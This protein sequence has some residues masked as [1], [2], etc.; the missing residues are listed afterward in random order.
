[1]SGMASLF[2][3]SGLFN[4]YALGNLDENKIHQV[5]VLSGAFLFST[6]KILQQLNG[7]DEG[8]FMYGEDIDLSYRIQQSGY[9]NFYL[10]NNPIVHFKGES[11]KK[12]KQYVK[13]FYNAMDVFL[14]KHY[15]G[16]SGK[17]LKVSVHIA[18]FLSQIKHQKKMNAVPETGSGHEH[19]I[20]IGDAA[21]VQAASMIFAT[22]HFSFEMVSQ[23]KE[24]IQN[25]LLLN[26][27]QQNTKLVFCIGA[28]TYRD[29]I[30]FLQN[31]KGRGAYLWFH[32]KA[33]TV[34]GCSDIISTSK[35]IYTSNK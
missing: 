26:I 6:K 25:P 2:P 21:S 27:T 23:Y 3:H 13:N 11:T 7:F 9:K 28:L 29:S 18:S 35:K 10:G 32:Q 22:H 15:K 5:D 24:A 4:K 17:L 14:D 34:I 8:F 30:E 20:L 1:M 19:Y 33:M 31:N 12:N 16:F